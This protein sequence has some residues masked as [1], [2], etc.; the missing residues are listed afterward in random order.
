M[1]AFHQSVHKIQNHCDRSVIAIHWLDLQQSL[2]PEAANSGGSQPR[3]H[4]GSIM[5]RTFEGGKS[6]QSE[7]L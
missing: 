2:V 4:G 1:T 3:E 7:L 6:Q 5:S